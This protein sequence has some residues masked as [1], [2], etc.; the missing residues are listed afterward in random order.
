MYSQEGDTKIVRRR[1]GLAGERGRGLGT[2]TWAWGSGLTKM[3]LRVSMAAPEWSEDSEL[4]RD[5][6]PAA[7]GEGV[8]VVVVVLAVVVLWLP[9]CLLGTLPCLVR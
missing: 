8:W 2:R 3:D 5:E 6:E 4:K 9:S 7:E 1:L